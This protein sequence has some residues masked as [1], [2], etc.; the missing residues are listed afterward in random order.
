MFYLPLTNHFSAREISDLTFA[1]GFGR[2]QR[3]RHGVGMEM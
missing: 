2:H 1:I 3:N